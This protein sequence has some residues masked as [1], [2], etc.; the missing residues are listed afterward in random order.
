MLVR[1]LLIRAFRVRTL[2]LGLVSIVSVVAIVSIVSIVSI[3]CAE[4]PPAAA[5]PQDAA[6]TLLAQGHQKSRMCL[7]CHGP[8]GISRVASYPSLAGRPAEYLTAQLTA[9]REG[10][11]ENPMM[12]SIARNLNDED[13]L[14]LAAYYADQIPAG[15]EEAID[16]ATEAAVEVQP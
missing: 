12:S 1:A 11:R 7:G 8:K 9:F 13:I 6:A 2:S 4:K 3:G 14:A 10:T 15:V 5:E 16:A